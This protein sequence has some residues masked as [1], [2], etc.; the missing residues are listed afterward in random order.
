MSLAHR[1]QARPAD[2]SHPARIQG[3]IGVDVHVR[4]RLCLPVDAGHRGG[5]GEGRVGTSVRSDEESETGVGDRKE[6]RQS[7]FAWQGKMEDAPVF[8]IDYEGLALFGHIRFC[9]VISGFGNKF[10]V[11]IFNEGRVFFH[12]VY[13]SGLIPR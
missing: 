6:F 10:I 8:V 11:T 1:R 13:N 9:S 12:N 7:Y 3:R 5:G 4:G 2:P